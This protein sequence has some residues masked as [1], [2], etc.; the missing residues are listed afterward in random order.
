MREGFL[1]S[2]CNVLITLTGNDWSKK[3]PL[4][5][6]GLLSR[7][8]QFGGA[9]ENLWDFQEVSELLERDRVFFTCTVVI[10]DRAFKH[11]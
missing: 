2:R 3:F 4:K 6:C 1:L 9:E 5:F 7:P 11:F 10:A 8:Q